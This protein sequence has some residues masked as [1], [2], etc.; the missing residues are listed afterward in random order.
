MKTGMS[1]EWYDKDEKS[2]L[3]IEK[4]ISIDWT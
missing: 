3:N 4:S 2:W 1:I